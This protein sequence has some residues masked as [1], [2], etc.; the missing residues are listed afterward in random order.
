MSAPT[1]VD[2]YARATG[3][4]VDGVI[5]LD[6]SVLTALLDYAGPIQL[7]TFDEQLDAYD[8]IRVIDALLVGTLPDPTTLARDLG[9]LAADRR[10]AVWTVDPAG[11]R[12]LEQ[13]GLAGS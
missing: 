2:T 5:G 10:L 9:P 4:T 1:R 6:P 12:L 8:A 7:T 11:Q 13:V 3:R